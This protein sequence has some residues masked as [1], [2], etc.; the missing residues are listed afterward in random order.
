M[1]RECPQ[2]CSKH[3]AF[4]EIDYNEFDELIDKGFTYA[5]I[6]EHYNISK[7]HFYQKIRKEIGELPSVYIAK[8]KGKYPSQKS[9]LKEIDPMGRVRTSSPDDEE[10][11]KLGQELVQWATE[12]TSELRYHIN[13]FWLLEKKLSRESLKRART[14]PVYRPYHDQAKAALA[15]R[16]VDGSINP[17]IAQRF[18]RLYFDDLREEEDYQVRLKAELQRMQKEEDNEQRIDEIRKALKELESISGAEEPS[19]STMED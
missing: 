1:S 8:R 15:N 3:P 10:L 4:I 18:L 11:E 5:Q 7:G 14:N 17:S 2:I 13:Q 9:K 12:P 19:E 6:R 16:Y